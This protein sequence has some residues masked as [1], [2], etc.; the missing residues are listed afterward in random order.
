MQWLYPSGHVLCTAVFDTFPIPFQRTLSVCQFYTLARNKRRWSTSTCTGPTR[1]EWSEP[2]VWRAVHDP[3]PIT[4]WL[5]LLESAGCSPSMMCNRVRGLRLACDY[6]YACYNTPKPRGLGELLAGKV[7]LYNRR[8]KD[9]ERYQDNPSATADTV[10][11]QLHRQ[12]FD[13]EDAQARLEQVLDRARRPGTATRGVLVRDA[14]L[15]GTVSDIRGLSAIRAVY[16]HHDASARRR[17]VPHRERR[18]AA[19]SNPQ[20]GSQNQVKARAHCHCAGWGR[21]ESPAGISLMSGPGAQWSQ[22][23]ST[24]SSTQVGV[25]FIPCSCFQ[26]WYKEAA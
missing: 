11:A 12:L 17:E 4:K 23:L 14:T 3:R 13:S 22:P 24:S 26:V 19:A 15:L 9:A 6:V 2:A 8:G 20:L 10:L 5:R 21:E 7:S 18:R 1:Q 25:R 16:A